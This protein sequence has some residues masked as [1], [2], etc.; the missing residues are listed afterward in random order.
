LA[1]TGREQIHVTKGGVAIRESGDSPPKALVAIEAWILSGSKR[2]GAAGEISRR[3]PAMANLARAKASAN[4]AAP[5]AVYRR[6]SA[7]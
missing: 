7:L 3:Y 1:E 6:C 4:P 2:A 5:V